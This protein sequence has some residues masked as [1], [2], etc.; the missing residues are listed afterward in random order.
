M[1]L[2]PTRSWDWQALAPI[3]FANA[4]WSEYGLC[5]CHHCISSGDQKDDMSPGGGA[6]ASKEDMFIAGVNP[7]VLSRPLLMRP[8]E[9]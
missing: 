7:I 5:N 4:F 3:A 1:N 6:P 8:T 9:L 2:S